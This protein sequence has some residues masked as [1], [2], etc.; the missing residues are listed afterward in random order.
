MDSVLIDSDVII[1][2]LT[3]RQPFAEDSAQILRLC[4]VGEI[5]G[6]V[7]AITLSN[8]YYI[9]RKLLSRDQIIFY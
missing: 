5:N 7:T 2:V 4:E 9:L 3:N 6:Y 8:I 1:D